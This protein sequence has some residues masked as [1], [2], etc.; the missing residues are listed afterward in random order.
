MY[1][2]KHRYKRN[3]RNSRHIRLTIILLFFLFGI[4]GTS[5]QIRRVMG[6][7]ASIQAQN[8][9]AR[10]V[11]NALSQLLMK[12]SFDIVQINSSDTGETVS[13][14]TD[15]GQLNKLSAEL[16]SVLMSELGKM[17]QQPMYISAGSL[18]G[19]DL[20][21]GLG[22]QIEFRAELRG[23]ISVDIT[24]QITE[25]G[26]NQ[27]LHRICCTV[28]AD[29]YIIL[30]GYRFKTTMKQTLPLAESIIVGDVPE[31]YTYVV[32][33]QSDTIGRI[34]DYGAGQ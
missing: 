18:T 22:P 10:S 2:V 29:F 33:D 23:G 20:F 21:A 3:S 13:I 28:T 7:I 16:T 14:Q 32:G 9:Y 8:Q 11:S 1:Y 17:E 26:I 25:T 4:I 34:F 5:I 19:I 6:D 15:T 24:S 31:A 27:S 12:E 30:P